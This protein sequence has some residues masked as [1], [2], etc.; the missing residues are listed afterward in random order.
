MSSPILNDE[1][2]ELRSIEL[3]FASQAFRIAIAPIPLALQ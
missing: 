2:V 3:D 1:C